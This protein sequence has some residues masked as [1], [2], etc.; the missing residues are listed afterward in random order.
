[1]GLIFPSTVGSVHIFVTSEK[2]PTE[3]PRAVG[4]FGAILCRNCLI[5]NSRSA[6]S[7]SAFYKIASKPAVSPAIFSG[8]AFYPGK[9]KKSV[10]HPTVFEKSAFFKQIAPKAALPI[11]E[12][13]EPAPSAPQRDLPKNLSFVHR[14]VQGNGVCAEDIPFERIQRKEEHRICCGEDLQTLLG[15]IAEDVAQK[16]KYIPIP[17]YA[18]YD[19]KRRKTKVA[20]DLV[21]ARTVGKT[22]RRFEAR[23]SSKPKNYSQAK[24][25]A[26]AGASKKGNAKVEELKRRL[27]LFLQCLIDAL[28]NSES[29]V[30]YKLGFVHL[31]R[32]DAEAPMQVRHI[33]FRAYSGDTLVGEP[34]FSI[35]IPVKEKGRLCV[36]PGSHKLVQADHWCKKRYIPETKRQAKLLDLLGDEDKKLV[37][38]GCKMQVVEF[39]TEQFVAF[40]DNTVHAGA[41]N[42]SGRCQLRLHFY[43]LREDAVLNEVETHVLKYWPWKLTDYY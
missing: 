14:V 30:K 7:R 34:N 29:D 31:I 21:H 3:N 23:I 16:R 25:Q 22:P 4:N 19:K 20:I 32:S 18:L 1:V 13:F 27:H 15:G 42:L 40:T 6:F 8:S 33:D 9:C 43:V 5:V 41:A 36:W 24:A 12:P 26:A 17:E 37:R 35:M 11:A 38:H 39:G 28:I 10:F 2:R